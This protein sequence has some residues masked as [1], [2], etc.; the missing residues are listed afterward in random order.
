MTAPERMQT[1]T[2]LRIVSRPTGPTSERWPVGCSSNANGPARHG[3]ARPMRHSPPAL[4]PRSRRRPVDQPEP[5]RSVSW[6]IAGFPAYGGGWWPWPARDGSAAS[7]LEGLELFRQGPPPFSRTRMVR[8]NL[9]EGNQRGH[10]DVRGRTEE[11]RERTDPGVS[12]GTDT[13]RR[14]S[15]PRHRGG[16]CEDSPVDLHHVGGRTAV[17]SPDVIERARSP[18]ILA[19]I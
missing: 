15:S 11:A 13:A 1:T 3:P 14:E 9:G 18:S 17:V 7:H 12:R 6:L 4:Q 8:Q 5:A 16:A 19:E 2:G 10:D